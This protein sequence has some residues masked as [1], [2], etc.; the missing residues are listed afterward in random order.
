MVDSP[1]RP[2]FRLGCT[3]YIYPDDILPNVRQLAG[4]VDDVELVLFELDDYSNLPDETA[5]AEL[6]HLATAHHLSYTVHLPLDL[7]VAPSD[8]SM[9][10]AQKIIRL[11][12]GL[13]PLAYI[14]HLD[15][16]EPLQTGQWDTWREA[17]MLGLEQLGREVRAPERICIENLEGWRH[18]EMYPILARLPVSFCLDIGHLWLRGLDAPAAIAQMADRTRVMHLHGI[19]ERDHKSL[20]HVPPE[21]LRAVLA[22]LDRAAYR[23]VVTLEVFSVEDF[24]PSRELVLKWCGLQE[25]FGHEFRTKWN[26]NSH[27][28]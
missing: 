16:R 19:A 2:A 28:R 8:P 15:A 10:K 24:F 17:C 3:S 5:L 6:Q 23:G 27:D 7:H 4:L 20:A 13:E 12:R 25:R 26:G 22:A 9:E 21:Q 1:P 11:T 14:A 18:E